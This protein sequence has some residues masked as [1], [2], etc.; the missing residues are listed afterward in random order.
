MWR[1][2]HP[3]VIWRGATT[4]PRSPQLGCTSIPKVAEV[5]GGR[6]CFG[7]LAATYADSGDLAPEGQAWRHRLHLCHDLQHCFRRS[8]GRVLVLA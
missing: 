1:H 2:A 7:E 5:G 4:I 8:I 3:A 6:H